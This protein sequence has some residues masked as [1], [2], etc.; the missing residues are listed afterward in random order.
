MITRYAQRNLVWVDLVNPS[1]NEMR[2]VMAEFDLHP[3]VAEELLMPSFKPKVER[4]GENI[5]LILHF[6]AMRVVG[7]RPE[8]EIDFVVGKNFL[9][10]TRYENVDP[11]HSF[12]KAFEVNAVL[13]R[14]H[15][16]HGGHLFV[17]MVRSLYQALGDECDAVHRRLQAIEENIFTGNERGMVIELSQVGRLIFDFRQSLM[18]HK[19]MLYSLEPAAGRMFGP[20][21]AYHI[22]N[23][24]GA[25]TRIAVTL[26]HLRDSLN[27]LRETNNSLLSTK[28]NDTM[29][30]FTV[31]AFIFLPLSFVAGLFGMNTMHNPIV[32]NS[33][34]FWIIVAGMAIL[35][36]SCI[37]YFKHKD[38]L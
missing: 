38:W 19:E 12:A 26:E 4:R 25:Y 29:K 24:E 27:E 36:V 8:V 33:Y 6:P 9:I 32:G 23:L 28:Q 10:T 5:F 3:G 15:A 18:P 37:F 17:E 21:F 31:L 20:E 34:D 22:R 1:A 14:A 30:I 7:S 11:L 2:Q 16:T 35:G 13:G